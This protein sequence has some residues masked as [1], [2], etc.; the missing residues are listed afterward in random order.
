MIAW[1]PWDYGHPG[2]VMFTI[3]PPPYP[4]PCPAPPPCV[5]A[6]MRARA[7]LSRPLPPP[8]WRA[9]A[10]MHACRRTV[11]RG[12][13]FF[14][15]LSPTIPHK[16]Y[17]PAPRHM[18]LYGP[19]GVSAAPLHRMQIVL[20]A[21]TCLFGS[22]GVELTLPLPCP[23]LLRPAPYA[24]MHACCNAGLVCCQDSERERLAPPHSMTALAFALARIAERGF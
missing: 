1:W 14:A 3:S 10:C 20:H 23:A 17:K 22:V 7:L 13:P 21:C 5:H 19:A 6:C 11:N 12:Q 2:L 8:G 4:R 9:C 15:M 18:R 16:P 24:H